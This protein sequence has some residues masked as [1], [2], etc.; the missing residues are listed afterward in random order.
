M[1]VKCD[2]KMQNFAKV[3][4]TPPLNSPTTAVYQDPGNELAWHYNIDLH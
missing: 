1:T 2:F 3:I 4:L